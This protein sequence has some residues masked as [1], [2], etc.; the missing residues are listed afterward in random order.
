LLL[1]FT[2]HQGLSRDTEFNDA[3][4]ASFLYLQIHSTPLLSLW[5][6]LP[7][8]PAAALDALIKLVL[9]R[10]QSWKNSKLLLRVFHF[11]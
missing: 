2:I 6:A 4:D 5:L 1:R 9:S 8:A 11:T 10:F 3:A 7:Q